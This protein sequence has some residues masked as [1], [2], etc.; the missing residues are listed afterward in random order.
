[1]LGTG[2]FAKVV[3]VRHRLSNKLFA[4]KVMQRQKIKTRNQVENTKSEL[5]LLQT[6]RHPF[7]IH[8][9]YAFTC[10]QN[11]YLVLDFCPGGDLFFYI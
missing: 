8:L 4:M 7:V 1:M 11:F 3:L 5:H 6:L 2:Q 9:N 10:P